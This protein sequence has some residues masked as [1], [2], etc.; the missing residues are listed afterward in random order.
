MRPWRPWTTPRSCT[1]W[2]GRHALVKQVMLS[3]AERFWSGNQNGKGKGKGGKFVQ[4]MGS[5]N[6]FSHLN[7]PGSS[8]WQ[9]WQ[10]QDGPRG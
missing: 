10:R 9:Q 4:D 8:S 7:T 6:M 1:P 3:Q 2:R 5:G